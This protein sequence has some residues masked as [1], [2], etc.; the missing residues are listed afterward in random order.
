MR[1]EPR[2]Q[3]LDRPPNWLP[4]LKSVP[5]CPASLKPSL[6]SLP[7]SLPK[8]LL[9]LPA[10]MADRLP[11]AKTGAVAEEEG[12]EDGSELLEAMEA[13][14]GLG[15][16]SAVDGVLL[17]VEEEEDGAEAVDEV[18]EVEEVGREEDT[19]MEAGNAA[20]PTDVGQLDDAAGCGAEVLDGSVL[21]A[22]F[23]PIPRASGWCAVD[24]GD[25]EEAASGPRLEPAND[26]VCGAAG[27]P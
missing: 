12:R 19:F 27:A 26:C 22:R 2:P 20:A 6:K 4:S 24:I 3:P 13:G 14:E 7:K 8:S 16:G 11:G 15:V 18:E 10:P 17:A 23:V 9:D 21:D 25:A 5:N 1:D